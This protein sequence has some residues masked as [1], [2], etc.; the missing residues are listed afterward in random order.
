MARRPSSLRADVL[1]EA[2]T[3]SVGGGCEV[4]LARRADREGFALLFYAQ[5]LASPH[6]SAGEPLAGSQFCAAHTRAL[7]GDARAASVLPS[8]V[9]ERLGDLHRAL[10]ADEA[11]APPCCPA[12]RREGQLVD[13]TVA[14]LLQRRDVV[15]LGRCTQVVLC[16]VHLP[17][18][19]RLV[20]PATPSPLVR[21]LVRGLRSP[22]GAA[23]L[24]TAVRGYDLDLRLRAETAGAVRLPKRTR[25][26]RR[27]PQLHELFGDLDL[28]ACP[29]CRAGVR[30]EEASL[31]WLT[32]R[33][34]RRMLASPPVALCPVHLG[35]LFRV[36]GPRRADEALELVAVALASEL[37]MAR[38]SSRLGSSAQRRKAV[39]GR[40]LAT[41]AGQACV[42]CFLRGSAERSVVELLLGAL[43]DPEVGG[44][45]RQ[46][47]GL[48][49]LH[50]AS[51]P[52]TES[53]KQIRSELLSRV[54]LAIWLLRLVVRAGDQGDQSDGMLP[55]EVRRVLLDSLT[56]L[57]GRIFLGS[58]P[59]AELLA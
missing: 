48:C 20:G 4:C 17:D 13:A 50:V 56:W 23:L 44:R 25:R 59:P 40:L 58:P 21:D 43:D 45:Y 10:G 7:L 19:L 9:L 12:C 28:G 11:V 24:G 16:P 37:E 14:A 30:A 51:V 18:V 38:P 47:H 6:R 2:A 33:R 26:L 49:A 29:A 22:A 35:D 8:V 3:P 32:A 34:H 27:L 54:D 53:G 42:A 5:A 55:V 15:R 57:D 46:A 1:G 31:R 52:L 39:L 41:A 36:A